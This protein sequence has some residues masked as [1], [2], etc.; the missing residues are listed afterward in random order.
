V[1]DLGCHRL[2]VAL[3]QHD[4]GTYA[5]CLDVGRY[6]ARIAAA[7]GLGADDARRAGDVGMLHDVG[8]VSVPVQLLRGDHRMTASQAAVMRGHAAVGGQLVAADARSAHL[9]P[10]VRAHHERVD[11]RGYPDALR[12]DAIPLESR[13][14]S[15]ADTFDA[16]TAGRPYR[17]P[18][19]V[20][21]ALTIL[22]ATRGRQWDPEIVEVFVALIEREGA[23]PRVVPA[24]TAV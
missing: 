14:V 3:R 21:D 20:G 19:S 22:T 9:A 18:G 5:H 4:E 24:A 15:V 13:I 11:G 1:D 17:R 23:V 2:L 7:M 16:L 8:K 6:A 10:L 12:G